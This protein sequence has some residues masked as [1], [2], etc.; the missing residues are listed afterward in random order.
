MLTPRPLQA[1]DSLSALTD[2]LHRAYAELGAMGLNYTAVDQSA[3]VTAQRLRGGQC[4]VVEAEGRLVGTVLVKPTDVD[5]E[6][7]YYATPGVASL[8]QFGVDPA[9]RGRGIGLRLVESCE[10]WARSQGFRALALD[11]ARP[12]THLV[13]LYAKLGYRTV[14]AVQWTGKTYESVVMAKGLDSA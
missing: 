14:G 10:A 7:A 13:A 9:W 2:L 5:S 8:R 11:T 12:A 4:F 1:S 6:C 3:E